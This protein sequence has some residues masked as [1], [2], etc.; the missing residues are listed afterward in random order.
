VAA[1]ERAEP[2]GEEYPG[3]G[4]EG[5]QSQAG[6]RAFPEALACSGPWPLGE[7]PRVLPLRPAA[8]VH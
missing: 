3:G 1:E 8:G 5:G 7:M 6:G 4:K 2:L